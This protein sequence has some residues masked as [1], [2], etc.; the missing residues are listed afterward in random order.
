M[1]YYNADYE[2]YQDAVIG[3]DGQLR[4]TTD[5]EKMLIYWIGRMSNPS[6]ACAKIGYAQFEYEPYREE[7][8]EMAAGE[9]AEHFHSTHHRH[10]DLENRIAKEIRIQQGKRRKK[11]RNT[12]TGEVFESMTEACRT[13]HIDKSNFSKAIRKHWR[14]GG[15]YWEY[16][17]HDSEKS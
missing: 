9:F 4:E 12:D 13:Y 5:L 1:Y 10:T 7:W 15:H 14:I 16:V 17:E 6:G 2:A 8:F 3:S 11:V